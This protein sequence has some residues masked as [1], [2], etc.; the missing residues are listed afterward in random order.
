MLKKKEEEEE[1][2]KE[3]LEKRQISDKNFKRVFLKTIFFETV[4][5]VQRKVLVNQADF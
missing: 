4:T 1:K 3:N 2:G 5:M